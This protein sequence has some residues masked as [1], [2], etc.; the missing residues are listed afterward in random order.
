MLL[1]HEMLS[2]LPDPDIRGQTL[3]HVEGV[4]FTLMQ[5]FPQLLQSALAL[6]LGRMHTKRKC[7]TRGGCAGRSWRRSWRACSALWAP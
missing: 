6:L 5:C 7:L 1:L 3:P 2:A 4:G